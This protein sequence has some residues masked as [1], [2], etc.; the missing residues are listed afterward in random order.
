[1][2]NR[3]RE[4]EGRENEERKESVAP[5][6]TVVDNLHSNG[7]D[8]RIHSAGAQLVDCSRSKS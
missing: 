1:V 8:L 2:G 5:A 3:E 6:K 4:R 7:N